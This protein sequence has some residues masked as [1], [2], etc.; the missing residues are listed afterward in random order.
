VRVP[1][2]VGLKLQDA[3]DELTGQGFKVGTVDQQPSDTVSKGVVL[4][5]SPKAG[6][7]APQ[8]EA[9]NLVV[10]SGKEQVAIPDEAGKDA[11]V[12]ANDLGQLGLKTATKQ[13]N[14]STVPNGKVIR[15]EPGPN[16]SVDKG[17]TVTLVVSQG[18]AQAT[19]PD[20]VGMTEAQATKTLKD[21]GFTVKTTDTPVTSDAEDGRVQ[22][23][24]PNA[25]TKADQ[26]SAVTITVGRKATTTT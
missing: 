20:V 19:V 14:S 24:N 2:V 25:G 22:A 23:Q 12:A 15:T 26:G 16:T 1:R 8:G 7:Q 4:E 18:P 13:E 6:D 9:V 3:Q 10:S 17:S 5:Q 21:A 11:A